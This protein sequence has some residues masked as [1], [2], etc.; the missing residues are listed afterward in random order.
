MKLKNFFCQFPNPWTLRVSGMG[1]YTSK[2]E[3]KSKSLHPSAH[4]IQSHMNNIQYIKYKHFSQMNRPQKATYIPRCRKKGAKPYRKRKK[5]KTIPQ[6]MQ[7]PIAW[8]KDI[9]YIYSKK[10]RN[11]F[12]KIPLEVHIF[13]LMYLQTSL[14]LL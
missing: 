1:G 2:C 4:T 5:L 9:L 6:A 7:W 11:R 12:H 3:K 13:C 10:S 14:S 8:I